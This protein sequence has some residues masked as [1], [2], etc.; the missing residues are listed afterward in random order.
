MALGDLRYIVARGFDSHLGT[1]L[2]GELLPKE[3]SEWTNLSS[4][5]GAGY[6]YAYVAEKG[7]ADLP[8]HIFTYVQTQQ[9]ARGLIK[10][11]DAPVTVEW[12]EPPEMD[13]ARQEKEAELESLAK[14]SEIAHEHAKA[15]LH[16]SQPKAVE[17]HA[18]EPKADVKRREAEAAVGSFEGQRYADLSK[19][20]LLDEVDKRNN[21]KSRKDEDRLAV[22]GT[23]TDLIERLVEDDLSKK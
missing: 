13:A 15:Q 17:Y 7:Y 16:V 9:E 5:V 18:P 21:Q 4:I 1:H 11:G 20:E 3:A 10:K 6:V 23:K 8:P 12:V 14:N 19:D 2:P 22:S